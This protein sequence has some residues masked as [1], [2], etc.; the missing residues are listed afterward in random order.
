MLPL[1]TKLYD[2]RV[3]GTNL[4]E[5]DEEF[6]INEYANYLLRPNIL[7]LFEILDFNPELLFSGSL[8]RGDN[9]YPIAWAYLRPVGSAHI[10]MTRSRL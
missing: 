5:W 6:V 8:A 4:A 2:L 10:H 1:S 7:I 9:L 3:K